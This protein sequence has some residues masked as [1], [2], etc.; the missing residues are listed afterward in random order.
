M[1]ASDGEIR[2]S[3]VTAVASVSTSPAPPRAK[4]PRWTRCQSFGRPSTEEYWHIGATN[5]R[6]R[7]VVPRRVRGSKSRL[8]LV[9][10]SAAAAPFPAPG[11][12]GE[13]HVVRPAPE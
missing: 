1:P 3:G 12:G 5:T 11:G 6:L 13:D 7:K 2:P 8:T 9:L 10:T 4:D